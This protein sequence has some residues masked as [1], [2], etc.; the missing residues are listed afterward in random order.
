MIEIAVQEIVTAD[1]EA[2]LNHF[3]CKLI[4]GVFRG[5]AKDVLNGASA[6]GD[7]SMFA[8]MLNTPIAELTMGNNVDTGQNFVDTRALWVCQYLSL[9]M[10]S[11]STNLVVLETILKNILHY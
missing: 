4:D 9:S 3:G 8:N 10:T 5:K 6:V 1:L 2:L 7:R 11:N